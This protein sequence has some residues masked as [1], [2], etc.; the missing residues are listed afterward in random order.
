M[1]YE[2]RKT[3]GGSTCQERVREGIKNNTK[4]GGGGGLTVPTSKHTG[5]LFGLRHVAVQEAKTEEK[6][7]SD[8]LLNFT[9]RTCP[10]VKD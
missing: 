10:R 9:H 4:P 2:V 8:F 5:I 3:T 7:S 6:V 1:I